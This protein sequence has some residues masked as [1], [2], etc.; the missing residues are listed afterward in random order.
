MNRF[1]VS[2][3]PLVMLAFGLTAYGDSFDAPGG[4]RS[5]LR[6]PARQASMRRASNPDQA[7]I[8]EPEVT[9]DD[10]PAQFQSPA[11]I[12]PAAPVGSGL[13]NATR[14]IF[15]GNYQGAGPAPVTAAPASN[16]ALHGEPGPNPAPAEGGFVGG[17]CEES[18]DCCNHL[19]DNYCQE[20]GHRCRKCKHGGKNDCAT[21]KSANCRPPRA[22][23]QDLFT[24]FK[25]QRAS[26]QACAC[27][28]ADCESCTTCEA[29]AAGHDVGLDAGLPPAPPAE[30]P[31]VQPGPD[32]PPAPMES[33]SDERAAMRRSNQ[34]LRG[35]FPIR[36]G[37][38][39]TI[40]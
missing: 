3:A 12:Q 16:T 6:A 27:E 37:E 22:Y 2:V 8:V 34:P 14:R 28:Q 23:R 29:G 36:F 35:L 25:N 31:A 32:A 9:A 18:N 13:I 7:T 15:A 39:P 24:H 21:C 11:Q 5:I 4:V 33:P 30:T 40:N 26:K 19:W 1:S 20:K 17:C 10:S 38:N